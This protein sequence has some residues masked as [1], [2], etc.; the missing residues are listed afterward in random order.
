[1][2]PSI[3][4]LEHILMLTDKVMK[5][6]LACEDK[7]NI[8]FSEA[9]CQPVI[10]TGIEWPHTNTDLKQDMREFYKSLKTYVDATI[11]S[12]LPNKPRD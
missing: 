8:I 1:M 9:I 3:A 6:N 10:N 5:S 4:R 12:Q 11:Q 7:Y 2:T